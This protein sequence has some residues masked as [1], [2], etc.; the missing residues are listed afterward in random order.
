MTQAAKKGLTREEAA[1]LYDSLKKRMESKHGKAGLAKLIDNERKKVG[2]EK[3]SPAI[4]AGLIDSLRPKAASAG[5]PL[6]NRQMSN[7]Q[8]ATGQK[9][10]ILLVVL[11]AGFKLTLSLFE[12]A[13][14]FKIEEANATL[15]KQP[16]QAAYLKPQF[17]KEEVSILKSLDSRRLELE[18]RRKNLEEEELEIR[19]KERE[20]AARLT[21]IKT[22]TQELK[23]DRVKDERKKKAQF[24]QLANVYGS[25]NPKEAAQ[26]IEQLDITIAKQLIE[27]MPE[28]RIA[29]I[30]ALMTPD[31]ALT[32]T[33]M[34][35]GSV[36]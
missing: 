23:E 12:A 16:Y 11:C 22:I 19:K 17:S 32:L 6:S 3:R 26:L 7:R 20:Y 5:L 25:M 33:R 35:T 30:L 21:E 2:S 27:R 15:Q 1:K 18:N 13:G 8:I 9:I 14:V 28:K 34:L 36:S 4:G 10:A 29:Q 24:D 31:R